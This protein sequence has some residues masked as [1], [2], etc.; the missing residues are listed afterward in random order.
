MNP[1]IILLLSLLL[2][3][4]PQIHMHRWIHMLKHYKYSIHR[5]T[6]T[7]S[8]SCKVQFKLLLNTDFC[9][10]KPHTYW[11]VL[12]TWSLTFLHSL[13]NPETESKWV[14]GHLLWKSAHKFSLALSLIH[15]CKPR[16]V[17]GSNW[18]AQPTWHCP[19]LPARP[20]FLKALTRRQA[21]A[22]VNNRLRGH[23]H[24]QKS[25]GRADFRLDQNRA[26]APFFS[27]ND[28]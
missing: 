10:E 1:S 5:L 23:P 2:I 17:E 4:Y 3:Y 25:R 20:R 26:L 28:G 22:T 13:K 6:H 8:S 9:T 12:P 24:K 19:A 14:E 7:L 16:K 27:V 21:L 11:W 18:T 15:N